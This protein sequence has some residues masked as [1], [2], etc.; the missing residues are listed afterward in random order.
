[1]WE[2]LKSIPVGYS[3]TF[4]L[5]AISAVVIVALRGHIKAIFGDKDIEIGHSGEK[6]SKGEN[7]LPA[8][9][10]P[11]TVTIV[12]KRSCG[13]CIL[14]LMGEREKFEIQIMQETH[15]ILRSQMSFTEQ[16][17]IEVQ[18]IIMRSMVETIHKNYAKNA[19]AV[20]ESVQY[21]LVYGLFKDAIWSVKD[22]IRRSFKDNGFYELS[23]S[24]FLS[25]TRDRVAIIHSIL[26][27]YVRNIFPDHA[28]VVSPQDIIDVFEKE[29]DFLSAIFIDIYTY[30]RGVK[31][32]AQNRIEAIMEEFKEWVDEFTH[33]SSKER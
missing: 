26:D 14:L 19:N 8:L 29:K 28:G 18:N 31:I 21:K 27:Q 13:D 32:E 2:F 7:K 10:P 25:Y 9:T 20:D 6:S 30:A 24:D 12:Q 15:R 16:K 4:L 5:L 11:P 1:M 33:N 22:E 17:L 23:N 3:F